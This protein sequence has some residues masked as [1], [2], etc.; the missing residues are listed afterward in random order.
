MIPP[1]LEAHDLGLRFGAIRALDR[2]S[3]Q[4][5]PGE[6]LAI[7]GESGS[8]KSTLLRV[9]AGEARPDA[10]AVL[11]RDPKGVQHDVHAMPEPRL[12]ALHRSDWASSTK[13]RAMRCAW[14]SPPAA[15]WGSG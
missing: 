12:R 14:Q 7:V 9:L 2:V 6:V 4:L 11:Y 10:G 13:T 15:M 1:L 5:W 3:L 8:G